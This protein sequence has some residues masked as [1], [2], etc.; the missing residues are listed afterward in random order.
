MKG[1]AKLWGAPGHR[2]LGE[3]PGAAQAPSGC[4]EQCIPAG[5]GT[6]NSTGTAPLGWAPFHPL[7][8]NTPF[9]S[10]AA[11]ICEHRHGKL[12]DVIHRRKILS[13][14]PEMTVTWQQDV[15]FPKGQETRTKGMLGT[16][17]AGRDHGAAPSPAIATARLHRTARGERFAPR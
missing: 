3:G 2:A 17:A 12:G 11:L 4:R 5:V 14:F 9:P 7:H 6:G 13:A 16:P 10:T 15:L 8:C 1:A